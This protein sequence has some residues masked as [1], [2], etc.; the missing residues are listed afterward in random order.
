MAGLA[1]HL[2]LHLH[3]HLHSLLSA[4]F[5]VGPIEWDLSRI[6]PEAR[7]NGFLESALTPGYDYGIVGVKGKALTTT[8]AESA[9]PSIMLLGGASLSVAG[10]DFLWANNCE[11]ERLV[12]VVDRDTP[13]RARGRERVRNVAGAGEKRQQVERQHN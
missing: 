1:Q 11:E 6:S 10:A 3:D 2:D 8:L 12:H 7:F 9:K 4:F 5:E 13:E